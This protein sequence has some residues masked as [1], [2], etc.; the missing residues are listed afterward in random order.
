MLLNTTESYAMLKIC[1]NFTV[2]FKARAISDP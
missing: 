1:S 2:Y